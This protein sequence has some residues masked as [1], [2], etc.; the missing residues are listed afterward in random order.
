MAV[1]DARAPK[2]VCSLAFS[3]DLEA[4][5]WDPHKPERLVGSC[6]DGTIRYVIMN[7][8]YAPKVT[9]KRFYSSTCVS[10]HRTL[11]SR[12]HFFDAHAHITVKKLLKRTTTQI[13]LFATVARPTSQI[14][15]LSNLGLQHGIFMSLS[16]SVPSHTVFVSFGREWK[17][18]AK[19]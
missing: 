13:V 18:A 10:L 5:A 9:E 11:H 3:S 14:S 7:C 16:S 12:V 17:S 6:D 4:I 8:L 2:S 19:R 15:R 1:L